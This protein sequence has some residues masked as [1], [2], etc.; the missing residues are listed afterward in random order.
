MGKLQKDT[1]QNVDI[2]DSTPPNEADVGNNH[3]ELGK[4]MCS[5]VKICQ[6]LY[7][8]LRCP[9]VHILQGLK[10]SAVKRWMELLVYMVVLCEV[11]L[12]C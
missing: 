6:I 9:L 5:K 10:L 4:Q 8:S 1:S 3:F 7:G 12:T 2:C 11:L